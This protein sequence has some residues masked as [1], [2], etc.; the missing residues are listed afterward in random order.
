MKML[1]FEPTPRE[2]NCVSGRGFTHWAM[3]A[4]DYLA[5]G[6]SIDLFFKD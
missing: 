5:V 3:E 4:I 1:R 6:R 2:N